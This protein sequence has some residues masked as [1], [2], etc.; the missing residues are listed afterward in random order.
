MDPLATEKAWPRANHGELMERYPGKYL[1]IEG[2]T[3]YGGFETYDRAVHAGAKMFGA[4]PFS[5]RSVLEPD[6][7]PPMVIPAIVA[8]IPL[9]ART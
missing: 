4:G 9:V 7:R 6:D 5:V 2:E 3:L 1:A 8:G